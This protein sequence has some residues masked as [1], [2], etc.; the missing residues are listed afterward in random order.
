MVIGTLSLLVTELGRQ[1]ADA[2]PGRNHFEK[3]L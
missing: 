2:G 3:Y 1:A